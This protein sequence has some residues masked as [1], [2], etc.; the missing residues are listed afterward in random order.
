MSFLQVIEGNT[1]VTKEPGFVV[2]GEV[3]GVL[4]QLVVGSVGRD[5][6]HLDRLLG[7]GEDSGKG[8]GGR[9]VDTVVDLELLVER[10]A[11]YVEGVAFVWDVGRN[12]RGWRKLAVKLV[13]L[14]TRF[15][16]RGEGGRKEVVLGL[17]GV[18]VDSGFVIKTTINK[19]SGEVEIFVVRSILAW[20]QESVLGL[21]DGVD[22][23][24]LT[25]DVDVV[26]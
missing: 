26:A 18:N 3:R 16:G 15:E 14:V 9:R 22:Y 13:E 24:L 8:F 19:A 5:Y 21:N 20:V 12:V 11:G 7:P 6:L 25:T 17:T 23:R 2:S 10:V 4:K 1:E